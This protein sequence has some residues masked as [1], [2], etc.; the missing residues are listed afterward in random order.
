M[1]NN[2]LDKVSMKTDKLPAARFN[3]SNDFNTTLQFGVVYPT[4]VKYCHEDTK[5]VDS[6]ETLFY[7]APMPVRTFGR[8]KAKLYH[9]FVSF[10]D[11]FPKLY[12]AIMSQTPY[13]AGVVGNINGGVLPYADSRIISSY[14]LLGSKLSIWLGTDYTATALSGLPALDS[15]PADRNVYSFCEKNAQGNSTPEWIFYAANQHQNNGLGNSSNLTTLSTSQSNMTQSWTAPEKNVFGAVLPQDTLLLN[16]FAFFTPDGQ[17]TPPVS[18]AYRRATLIPLGNST[19]YSVCSD[20]LRNHGTSY[21]DLKRQ[22]YDTEYYNPQNSDVVVCKIWTYSEGSGQNVTW[23]RRRAYFCFRL[24]D[25]GKRF[26]AFLEG[27]DYKLDFHTGTNWALAPLLA[28]YKAYYDLFSINLY[29][30]FENSAIGKLCTAIDNGAYWSDFNN[31]VAHLETCD[32][33]TPYTDGLL[34]RIVY[35][36]GDMFYTKEQDYLSA[37]IPNTGVSPNVR[38][39]VGIAYDVD[40]Q[41]HIDAATSQHEHNYSAQ[42]GQAHAW[43]DNPIHGQLDSEFLKRAYRWVNRNSIAGQRIADL[44]RA[45][46]LGDYVNQCKSNFIGTE[47]VSLKIDSILAQADTYQSGTDGAQLGQRAGVGVGYSDGSKSFTFT[48]NEVGLIISFV[49][50]VPNSGYCQGSSPVLTKLIG[51]NNFYQPIADALGME[52]TTFESIVDTMKEDGSAIVPMK[53]F[54]LVPQESKFKVARNKMSGGFTLPSE[55]DSFLPYTLDYYMP[56]NKLVLKNIYKDPVY[57]PKMSAVLINPLQMDAIPTCGEP[58][59]KIGKYMYIQNL[60]RMF[61]YRGV[62]ES[63]ASSVVGNN[64]SEYIVRTADNFIM[65]MIDNDQ[66][67][68]HMKPIEESF[69]TDDEGK[70]DTSMTKA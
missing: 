57:E 44:L 60:N 59:R 38:S 21:Y 34:G 58:W 20:W 41:A 30:N 15:V 6:R 22:G 48:N 1:R 5:K 26:K 37:H 62:E 29:E 45:Q 35:S 56:L 9:Q 51:K 24:S 52:A 11:L 4:H 53:T 27:C 49:C 55:Q 12:P 10:Q 65:Q 23:H 46:G 2:V 61:S 67:W 18:D 36:F 68:A 69:E 66:S 25:Y 47:D 13:A 54:G 28:T 14:A 8:L 70:T 50:I 64:W 40:N 32:F 3:L 16:P 7:L 19:R 33:G 43:I 39:A 42:S 31:L 17:N 63:L